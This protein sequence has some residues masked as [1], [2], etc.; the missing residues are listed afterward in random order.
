MKYLSVLA[1]LFTSWIL[2][3]QEKPQ[4]FMLGDIAYPITTIKKSP[5]SDLQFF[6]LSGGRFLL[7]DIG[8]GRLNEQSAPRRKNFSVKGFQYGGDAEFSA[9]QRFILVTE[10]NLMI[11]YDKV[12]VEPFRLVVLETATG[13]LLFEHEGVMQAQFVK[14]MPV[15][16]AFLEEEIITYD[17]ESKQLTTVKAPLEIESGCLNQA[18]NLLAIAYDPVMEEFKLKH[19]AGLNRKELKNARKNKKL[20]AFYEYPSMIRTAALQEEIDVVYTM[21]FIDNDKYL[22]FFSRSKQAEHQHATGLNSMDKLRDLNQFQRVDM[23][24]RVVDNLNF[25]YQTSEAQSNFDLDL[26]SGLFIYGDNRGFLSAK[27]EVVVVNFNQQQDYLGKYTYQG[28]AG[29]RNLYSTA[30]SLLDQN[31]ILVANGMKLSY[32]NFRQFPQYSEFIEPMNENAILDKAVNQLNT[33]LDSPE[34]AL[35]K[36]IKKKNI[37]GLFIFNITIQKNGEVISVFAQSD[38]RTDIQAQNQL[39]DLMMKYKFDVSVPKNERVK[40]T[41]TFNL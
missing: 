36:S 12:Q 31:T 11:T 6:S 15:V 10:Q 37:Q 33:D 40:F 27:R 34:S 41:Y 30:F 39:K 4:S 21:R 26:N 35:M 9:D 1:L 19:G 3:A 24:N 22:L 32:W 5:A 14:G 20:L 29:S 8:K 25:I 16:M 13:N 23:S 2:A 7:Y 28:R 18:G 38:D 17:L